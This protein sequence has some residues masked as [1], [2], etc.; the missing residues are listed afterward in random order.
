MSV[1]NFLKNIEKQFA[2]ADEQAIIQIAEESLYAFVQSSGMTKTEPIFNAMVIIAKIGC[3]ASVQLSEKQ[4]HLA[5]DQFTR[6]YKGSMEK[7]YPMLTGDVSEQEYGMMNLFC[8][9]GQDRLG[10]PLLT[11]ILCYAYIDG[12]PSIALEEKLESIFGMVLLQHFLNGDPEDDASDED[13]E[14]DHNSF[15]CFVC[16]KTFSKNDGVA[17]SEDFYVCKHCHATQFGGQAKTEAEQN[18]EN[19]RLAEESEKK[20]RRQEIDQYSRAFKQ[21]EKDVSQTEAKRTEEAE[22]QIQKFKQELEKEAHNKFDKAQNNCQQNI[23]KY[24]NIK[25]SAE[26]KLATLGFF[27]FGEKSEQKAIIKDAVLKITEAEEAIANAK[28]V[29]DSEV[30]GIPQKAENRKAAVIE[31]VEKDICM[32][33]APTKPAHMNQNERDFLMQAILDSMEDGKRYTC[34]EIAEQLN[35]IPGF[36][37]IS[38]NYVSSLTRQLIEHGKLKR[39]VDRGRALFELC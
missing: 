12:T 8:Q 17:L 30:A 19:T 11:Y 2:G 5:D 13:E 32:P 33:N 14:P 29:Y 10:I 18:K 6:V 26:A 3:E 9:L 28:K 20:R 4:K 16:G 15:C 37:D 31:Q 36:E 24:T 34:F 22:R 38:V 39:T 1:G 25:N 23:D 21:W 35:K 7:I 27:K